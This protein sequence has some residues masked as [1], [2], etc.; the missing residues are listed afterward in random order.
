MQTL[1]NPLAQNLLLSNEDLS[2]T[3][4]MTKTEQMALFRPGSI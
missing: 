3:I 4:R 1:D 2:Y